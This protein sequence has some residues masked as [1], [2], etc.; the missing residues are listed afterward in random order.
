[1]TVDADTHPGAAAAGAGDTGR[2]W[3]VGVLVG[4]ALAWLAA[5]LWSAHATITGSDGDA[6]LA[7]NRAALTLPS[8]VTASL[9]AGVAVGLG[10]VGVVGR[11][12]RAGR[13]SAR[14]AVATGAGLVAGL[15]VAALIL[16]AYGTGSSLVV[17]AGTVAVAGAIGG[18]V[19][20]VRP[21][22]I[23]GAAI[24]GALAWFLVGLL[25]GAFNNRLLDLLG[26]SDSPASRVSATSRLLLTVAVVGGIVAGLTA[27][28]YLRRRGAGLRWP[29]YL[30]AGAGP[31]LLLLLANLVALVG[32]ARLRSLAAGS[33]EA[34]SAA[35]DYIGTAGINT[36]LVVL[37]VGAITA[38]VAF[39]RTLRPPTSE[40]E[41]D[42]TS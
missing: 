39:G 12:Q 35:L 41:P 34:D 14:F 32:G 23:V 40:A 26:G 5:T 25:Q 37:F 9:V 8:V 21:A 13:S 4:L 15:I 24:A 31:G 33:S 29:A 10:A 6:A 2:G 19:G 30:A 18:A 36:G 3:S 1:M 17:L 7:L 22:G 38:M 27:F 11:R 28:R 20:A 16:A 42:Q